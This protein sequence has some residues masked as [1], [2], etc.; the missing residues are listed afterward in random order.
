MRG[1][2]TQRILQFILDLS[3]SSDCESVQANG[4][5]GDVSTQALQSITLIGLTRNGGIE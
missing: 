5:S 2:V 4:W 3:I 1:A